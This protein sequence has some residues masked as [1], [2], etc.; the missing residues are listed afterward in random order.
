MMHDDLIADSRF[1][2]HVEGVE[3][4]RQRN[5]GR[6][7]LTGVIVGAGVGDHQGV[8]GR[9][10]RIEEQLAILGADVA[11]PRHRMAGQRIITVDGADPGKDGVVQADQA[12]HPVR[13]RTHRH[14]GA[15]RQRAGAEVGPGGPTGEVLMQQRIHIR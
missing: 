12:H 9:A 10:D 13:H 15:H 4:L 7:L 11:L 14:H 8:G 6:A 5:R 3:Q 2:G 1:G